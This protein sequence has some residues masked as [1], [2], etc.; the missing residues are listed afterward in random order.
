MELEI[1]M[2][3]QIVMGPSGEMASCPENVKIGVPVWSATWMSACPG[4]QLGR[5]PVAAAK[6]IASRFKRR[7]DGEDAARRK[8]EQSL[9]PARSGHS[10][11]PASRFRSRSWISRSHARPASRAFGLAGWSGFAAR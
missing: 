9:W 3:F 10:S 4:G 7:D 1:E 11:S 6:T 8:L 5:L 2:S